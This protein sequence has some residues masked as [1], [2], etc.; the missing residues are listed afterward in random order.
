MARDLCSNVGCY[1]LFSILLSIV[2]GA[3]SL[4]VFGDDGITIAIPVMTS[5]VNLDG[6]IGVDNEWK[7]AFVISFPGARSDGQNVT[8]YLK[9]EPNSKVL[10]GAFSIPGKS[11]VP[12][13]SSEGIH[14]LFD[15]AGSINENLN[16][17][18]HDIAFYRDKTVRYFIGDKEKGWITNVTSVSSETELPL[19]DPFSKLDFRIITAADGWSGEFKIDLRSDPSLYGFSIVTQTD[20]TTRTGRQEPQ[21]T[22]YPSTLN[23]TDPSTWTKISFK[24]NATSGTARTVPDNIGSNAPENVSLTPG[25][26]SENTT[27]PLENEGPKINIT[28]LSPINVPAVS[29]T[30][31]SVSYTAT[32]TD[33]ED[34]NIT[35]ECNPPSGSIF[36]IGSTKVTCTTKDSDDKE[37]VESLIVN[38]MELP[39]YQK[40]EYIVPIVTVIISSI[41]GPIVVARYGQKKR[42]KDRSN[43]KRQ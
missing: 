3:C 10:Y 37:A 29:S 39:W 25:Q 41:I 17:K 23:V 1:L 28:P 27:Q 12:S 9:Y 15:T 31:T 13:Q 20:V 26:V 38:V 7:D 21:S 30:G 42:S 18:D 32:A 8:V 4:R 6:N 33:K 2:I 14:F 34:G 16:N 22:R 40:P 11:P 5:E 24:E 19:Q 36:Q 43:R 35:P